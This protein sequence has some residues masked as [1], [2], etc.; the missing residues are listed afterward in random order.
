L[1]ET[2]RWTR[3]GTERVRVR[4]DAGA[5]LP[6][7]VTSFSCLSL[8]R[9]LWTSHRMHRYQVGEKLGD[10]TYGEVLR[11]TNKTSGEVV[12]IKRFRTYPSC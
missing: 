12:A 6:R 2:K 4:S 9:A 8:S 5:A 10:G 7:P 1:E 3:C 11:A